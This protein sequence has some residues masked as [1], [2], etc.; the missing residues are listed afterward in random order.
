MTLCFVH[1]LCLLKSKEENFLEL[2]TSKDEPYA[3]FDGSMDFD[4]FDPSDS[5]TYEKYRL[6]VHA[7][8]KHIFM[9]RPSGPYVR[10]LLFYATTDTY[11]R[12][13]YDTL[14]LSKNFKLLKVLD[15]EC[16]N[17]GNSF[18]NGIE[19]LVQ[20]HYLAVGGDIDSIPSS[21]ANLQNLETFLV[22]GLKGKVTIP[23]S[24]WTMTSLRHLHVENHA[25]FA[26]QD[27]KIGSSC[28]LSNLVSLSSP[29]L[30]YREHAEEILRGLPNLQKLSCIFSKSWD[31]SKKCNQFPRLEDMT[32]LESLKI[33]YIGRSVSSGEFSFPLSLRKLTLSTFFLRWD[34]IS[35]IGCPENLEV[36]K[37]LSITFES[38]QWEMQDGEFPEL[39]FLK[40]HNSNIVDWNASCDHLPNLQQLVLQKCDNLREV[41]IDFVDITTLQVI[42]VQRCGDSVEESVRR[43]K[44]EEQIRYGTENLKVLIHH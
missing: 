10:S 25:T 6:C 26:L 14:F 20:L 2:V 37:L 34:H 43:L 39:K 9:S 32:P 8:R 4:D 23:D 36:L 12:C 28:E 29:S 21:L 5:M 17:M 7:S 3:S 44:E 27:G 42:E 15:L 19:L 40:L 11:P 38:T 18:A 31:N 30:S 16:V 35:T 24:I 1:C 22:K 41:P 13:P 33:S